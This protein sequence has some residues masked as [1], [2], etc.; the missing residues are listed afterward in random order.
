MTAKKH[1]VN[2]D[3]VRA[4][5]T[6]FIVFIH[7][8][9]NT[10]L[11][12]SCP[13]LPL[14]LA[15]VGLRMIVGSSVAVFM[16][17]T[18]YLCSEKKLS[19]RYYLGFLRIYETYLLCSAMAF[20]A[21]ALLLHE[22]LSL[23]YM[24]GAVVNFYSIDYAWYL[25]MY[26]GLFLM[27]PFL[28]LAFNGLESDRQRLV[29]IGTFLY[30]SILP[31]LL[32]VKVQ[33]LSVWWKNLSPITYYFT[34]A[35]LRRTK[36]RVSA[37]KAAGLLLLLVA[38]FVAVDAALLGTGGGWTIVVTRHDHY[39]GYV[40][41]LLCFLILQNA[42]ADRLPARAQRWIGRFSALSLPTFLLSWITDALLYPWFKS[43]VPDLNR[44][45]WYLLPIGLLSFLG[46]TMLA[47][48]EECIRKPLDKAVSGLLFRLIP[49]LK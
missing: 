32:N 39:Q 42:G 41:A 3:F 1:D 31:S 34:G 29:L 12:E 5:A 8:Y 9:D 40:C 37:K 46:A 22:E 47:E 7:F 43:A 15:S 30:L 45:F 13:A 49:T 24:V 28:N 4:V 48:L 26:L 19:L 44:A 16:M 35:Y 14:R 33:L 27:I 10:G 17:L 6:L 36:P 21:R 38:A 18:G 2:L 20:L 23:S 11:Y 25:L